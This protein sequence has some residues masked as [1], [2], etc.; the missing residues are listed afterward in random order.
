MSDGGAKARL[1]HKVCDAHLARIV[2][3]DL[4]SDLFTYALD[5]GALAQAEL[6]DG[7]LLLVSN[8]ADLTPTQL[9]QR[10]K[11]LADIERGFK[12]PKSEIEI[13]PV[14]HRLAERIR[15]H[16]MLCFMALIVYRVMRQRLKL[17]KSELRPERALTQLRRNKSL[18][19]NL[20][21]GCLIYGQ[22][23]SGTASA[24]TPQRPSRASPP[25]TTNRP[26]CWPH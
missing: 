2:K 5:E 3:V 4:K 18:S 20:A 13:A 21:R 1:C 17:A 15:A 22:A 23:L 16:A 24:S 12:V 7:K 10:Y 19:V 6:M 11:A 26:M 9:V 14:Y 25:S 8:V